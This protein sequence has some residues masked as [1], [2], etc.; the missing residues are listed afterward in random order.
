[1]TS[2]FVRSDSIT[3][4]MIRDPAFKGDP[5]SDLPM[6]P[7]MT[8]YSEPSSVFGSVFDDAALCSWSE[9]A[10]AREAEELYGFEFDGCIFS[11]VTARRADGQHVLGPTDEVPCGL[12]MHPMLR[13]RGTYEPPEIFSREGHVYQFREEGTMPPDMGD[14][15]LDAV[16]SFN[17][18]ML[19][20]DLDEEVRGLLME[21]GERVRRRELSRH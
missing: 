15:V 5:T 16:Y 6:P 11:S 10:V 13:W 7:H 8:D 12:P 14:A 19:F 18:R 17:H 2:P 1:M 20:V 3:E 21:T 9:S 4:S